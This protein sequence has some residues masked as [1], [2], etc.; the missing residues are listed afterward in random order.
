[1]DAQASFGDEHADVPK[2]SSFHFLKLCRKNTY[3][4]YFSEKK[5]DK[6]H[7][8]LNEASCNYKQRFFE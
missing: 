1:M 3:L 8:R 4:N 5:N 6:Q 7:R 2:L